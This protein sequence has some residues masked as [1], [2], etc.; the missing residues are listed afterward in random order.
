MAQLRNSRPPK[1]QP[2][3]QV[4]KITETVEAIP[5]QITHPP[6]WTKY[7][8]VTEIVVSAE[9]AFEI[10][11]VI[12]VGTI[13]IPSIIDEHWGIPPITVTEVRKAD[14][15]LKSG[16]WI[17]RDDVVPTSG[18]TYDP[19]PGNKIVRVF[20]GHWQA[21]QDYLIVNYC[22]FPTHL[23]LELQKQ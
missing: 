15:L 5:V 20:D 1:D 22:V 17:G 23:E 12:Q 16:E 13:S 14:S 19:T 18:K 2:L 21:D 6:E 3:P 4:E 9:P 8:A 11:S 7:I 10:P